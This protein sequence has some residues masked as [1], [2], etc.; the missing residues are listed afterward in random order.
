MAEQYSTHVRSSSME[1]HHQ[2]QFHVILRTPLFWG[3]SYPSAKD[4]IRSNN[5][6]VFKPAVLCFKVNLVL[7]PWF[8]GCINP[9]NISTQDNIR[10]Q[11]L[12]FSLQTFRK[13]RTSPQGNWWQQGIIII[14]YSFIPRYG[15]YSTI[16]VLQKGWRGD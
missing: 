11:T 10:L 3:V 4:T 2:I 14:F 5:I 1:S 8:R 9:N 6:A 7:Y 15:F 13:T 12:F 16:T